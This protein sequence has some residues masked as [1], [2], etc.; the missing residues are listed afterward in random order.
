MMEGRVI[1][2]HGRQYVVELPDGTRLPCV[3]R[4]KKSEVVC[5]DRLDIER[6]SD[7]QGVIEGIQP[8]SSLLHRS[9]EHKQ[10]LIAANVDQ[11]VVVVATEPAFS[12]EL[13]TRA[14]LAAESEEI[15]PLIVLNKCD[16]S[17]K[18]PAARER[19]KIFAEIGYP[20][21]ELSA[22][23]HAEDLRPSLHGVTSV[24]VGQSG[25]GKSTLVNALVPEAN[26]ATREIS[27]ALD[28]GKHTT[29]H[30]TLYHLDSESHLIDSPG[31]QEFGLGHLD[32]QDIEYAFR[33]F[34]PFLGQCRFR[35]CQH[36][37]EPDC[38][39]TAAVNAG[40]INERRFAVYHR[41]M[42]TLRPS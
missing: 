11:L 42:G 3:P 17:D 15:R 13:L 29:T 30:A 8:R 25:M 41:L 2:A 38:A 28:S 23:A 10:K 40:K 36:N 19:L 9:N 21:L 35:D 37:R 24:L 4:G 1:A 20:I 14:L 6:T 12:D 27:L 5:G 16:L 32:R 39:L 31:L 7:N 34:R 26:A 22:L 33:E 18:L